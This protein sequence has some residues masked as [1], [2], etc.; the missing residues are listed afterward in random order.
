MGIVSLIVMEP[1]SAWPGHVGDSENVV[2]VG[3]HHDEALLQ[4]IRQRLDSLRLKGD[5]VRVAVLA[6]NGAT[7]GAS[8]ARRAEI[9]HELL[10]AV[11]A[12]GFGRLVLDVATRASPQLRL[13]LLA[14]AGGLSHA[15]AGGSVVSVRF[16]EP[17]ER[18]ASRSRGP[19]ARLAMAGSTRRSPP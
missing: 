10:S 1:G 2:E 9:A 18:S 13:E 19:D 12:V 8:L 3:E 15:R 7:D 6:C 11:A 4:R 17:S 5:R 16:N 14:L